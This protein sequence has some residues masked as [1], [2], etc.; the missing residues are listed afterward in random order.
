MTIQIDPIAATPHTIAPQP[1]TIWQ[2]RSVDSTAPIVMIV[3]VANPLEVDAPRS[4]R[5]MWLARDVQFQSDI[6]VVVP[7]SVSGDRQDLV[8]LTWQVFSLDQA[9]LVQ[10]TGIRLSRAI[11]DCL[12]DIGD[13]HHGLTTTQVDPADYG[14]IAS[15]TGSHQQAAI[16]GFHAQQSA[17]VADLAHRCWQATHAFHALRATT[18]LLEAAIAQ[19]IDLNPN[20][21]LSQTLQAHWHSLS[22][23]C[24]TTTEQTI[25]DWQRLLGSMIPPQVA[26]AL[27]CP[28]DATPDP[29]QRS[30][31]IANLV[32]Q[33]QTTPDDETLWET[34]ECLWAI[35]PGNPAAGVRRVKLVDLGMQVAGEAV[36]LAVAIVPRAMAMAVL[37]QVYPTGNTA[38]LPEDLQLIVL[39]ESGQVLRQVTARPADIYIQ[40]KL[41]GTTG[42]RFSVRVALGES[43]LTENFVI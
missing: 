34:V 20:A 11:Y 1:G 17:I 36:A 15:P 4:V 32:T 19:E 29:A 26:P 5:V 8:A 13:R 12:L 9:D 40:L 28:P 25:G 31:A 41:S 37:L 24:E 7:R 6:D 38:Y 22:H 18:Q 10:P 23:W 42:E 35:D 33:L 21:T 2:V 3:D 30:T 16:Q 27:R 39:D 43:G 14:L